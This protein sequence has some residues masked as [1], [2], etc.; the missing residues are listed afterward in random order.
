MFKSESGKKEEAMQKE[1][2]RNELQK[3]VGLYDVLKKYLTIYLA[4]VAIP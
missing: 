2:T 3:D 1:T 4:T